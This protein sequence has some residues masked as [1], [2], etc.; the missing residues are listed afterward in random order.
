MKTMTK[1]KWILAGAFLA[2]L[3]IV[4]Q[5]CTKNKE[6]DIKISDNGGHSHHAGENCM[7]CHK[8]GGPGDGWFTVAGTAYDSISGNTVSGTTV[9]L[10][11]ARNGRGI[12]KHTLNGDG[13]GNFY[14]TENVDF[15]SGLYPVVKGPN[16]IR[17][18]TTSIT[19]GQ[20]N[21]CHGISSPKI[22]AP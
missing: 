22:V 9:Y 3:F 2:S 15:S 7:N 21:N 19:M 4:L 8:Q 17:Y 10:Y 20:C 12:L 14:T 16:G 11:T 1:S 13:S 6:N 18:M 5:S